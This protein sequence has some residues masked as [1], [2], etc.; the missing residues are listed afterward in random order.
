MISHGTRGLIIA[1]LLAVVGGALY[2]SWRNDGV[3]AGWTNN[4]YGPLSP[5]DRDFLVKVRQ[6]G[7]WE[8]PVGQE[9]QARASQSRVREIAGF[10]HQEHQELDAKTIETAKTLGVELPSLPSNEQRLWMQ[11]ISNKTGTAYDATAV[12]RLREAHGIVLPIIAQVRTGTRNSL[13]RAFAEDADQYVTRHIGYLES[14]GLVDF[15]SLPEPST[16]LAPTSNA[17]TVGGALLLVMLCVVGLLILF[18]L[19]AKRSRI[20]RPRPEPR[21]ARGKVADAA[22]DHQRSS[23]HS[24]TT[25][26][27]RRSGI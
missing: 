14:T 2:T 9:M 16:A 17:R 24:R 1:L 7:L 26:H 27:A 25:R 15:G 18:L 19:L 6:A 21:H 13:V 4:Q 3:T 12:Q 11:E 8:M 10:I 5:A 22:T 20:P 23:G